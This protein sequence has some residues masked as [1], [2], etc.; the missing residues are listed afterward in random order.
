[1]LSSLERG[2]GDSRLP[3]AAMLLDEL[4]LDE[5]FVEFLTLPGYRLLG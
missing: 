2:A 1:M 4:V 5:G 3:E